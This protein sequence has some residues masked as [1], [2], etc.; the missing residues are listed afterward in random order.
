MRTLAPAVLVLVGLSIFGCG[1]TPAQPDLA[2]A[3]QTVG[4]N[5]TQAPVQS[6]TS[7]R[8]ITSKP[9]IDPT[10][11]NGTTVYM[12]GSH[13]IVGARESMPEAYAHAEEL[14][15]VVYPQKTTP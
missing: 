9:D 8:T 5:S 3:G 14:Y 2:T 4:P 13:M 6:Q 7:T 12:I 1:R 15:L 11:A 10:Y